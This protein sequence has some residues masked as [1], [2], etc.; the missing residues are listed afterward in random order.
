MEEVIQGYR[1]EREQ[2][3]HVSDIHRIQKIAYAPDVLLVQLKRFNFRGQKDSSKIAY[4]PRLDLSPHSANDSLGPLAYDLTAVISH[5]G[6]A[7]FGH[8]Q[9]IAKTPKGAWCEFDDTSTQ[10]LDI[11]YALNPSL[12]DPDW[13]PYLLFYERNK[14]SMPPL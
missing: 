11:K 14:A 5:S 1:C 4:G 13:T 10:L 7:G 2:C 12:I 6:T 8:Y 3:K 9:C